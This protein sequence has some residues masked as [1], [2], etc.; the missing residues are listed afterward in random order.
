[1]IVLGIPCHAQWR[2]ARGIELGG[3]GHFGYDLEYVPI[4]D[5]QQ[6]AKAPRT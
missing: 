5:L 2:T 4:E 3:P 1:V 6:T